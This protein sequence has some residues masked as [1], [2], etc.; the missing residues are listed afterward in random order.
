MVTPTPAPTPVVVTGTPT[1]PKITVAKRGPRTARSGRTVTFTVIVKNTSA[2]VVARSVIV[3]DL[4]PA[5]YFVV[6]IPNG[7]RFIKGN[8]VWN[9]GELAPG[10]TKTLRIR[11]RVDR[12]V[13]GNRCNVVEVVAG[14][15]PP[16][17]ARTCTKIVRVRGVPPTPVTG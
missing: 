1:P 13:T 3:R 10:A 8:L 9:L 7:A 2:S 12:S 6:K 4:L 16:V 11:I 5:G 15:A 14:N 17:N